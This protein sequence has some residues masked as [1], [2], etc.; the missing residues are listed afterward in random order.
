M[1]L[2]DFAGQSAQAGTLVFVGYLALISISLG[3]LNLLP[4]P[5]LDGGQIVMQAIGPR[6]YPLTLDGI[7]LGAGTATAAGGYTYSASSLSLTPGDTLDFTVGFGTAE[8]A[9][10]GFEGPITGSAAPVGGIDQYSWRRKWPPPCAGQDFRPHCCI[11][12]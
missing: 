2:A 12:I 6:M 1:T 5:I 7:A 10:I 4:I 3:V 9:S 11:A 8:G